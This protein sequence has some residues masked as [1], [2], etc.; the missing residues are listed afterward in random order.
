[1]QD[2]YDWVDARRD[3]LVAEL[4]ALLRQPSISA[5]GVGLEACAEL[6]MGQLHAD[7]ITSA[8]IEPVPGAPP[9][10]Y[11]TVPAA[12]PGAKTLL[13]YGHY[14]VQPPEPLELWVDPPFSAA[15][16][17]GVIYARGATDNKSGV[18][19]FT[20]AAQ[21]FNELR[22]GPP[23]NLTLLFEGEEELG[24]PH[25]EGWVLNH[26]ELCACDASVGLDGGVHRTSYKPEIHLGIK[27][28]LVV[29]L[30]A[31]SHGI[32][33][34]SGRAQLMK[35]QSAP[36]RIVHALGSMFD[37]EGRI[38][39][40]GWY[41]DL[42]PPDEDDLRHLREELAHFDRAELARQLGVSRDFP[43]DDT[44]ELLKAIHYGASCNIN[45]LGAGYT[46]QGSKTIVPAEAMA[47][48]DFRCPPNLEPADQLKKLE[49]HLRRHGF[50]D[51]ELVV[52]TARANP[53]KTP[54]REA[55]SQ[56]VIGAADTIWGEPPLVMGVSTQGTIM[57]HVPH[58]AVL[59][60]FG[61][62]EN[63]LHAPN[64]NM[65]IERYLQGIKFA[66]TIFQEFADRMERP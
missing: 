63:N 56:A 50:D 55:I 40:D 25:L 36:W 65:P 6:L 66:A 21:A 8:R 64:E 30:R 44:L 60:G 48:L 59:S 29:E 46:G 17:D 24:S 62:P 42:I 11:A 16:R 49:A 9:I 5:Q 4:Q 52:H 20:R 47:R 38:T 33:F 35:A 45:G 34:W 1:M 39:I 31:R 53:Y 19:A 2:I 15:I 7:G 41:D 12:R 13:C 37:R 23:V 43:F 28:I 26:Q 57:I 54:V 18:L 32:D 10:V 14:D 58:P 22:G 51:L 27:A 61:A 3:E